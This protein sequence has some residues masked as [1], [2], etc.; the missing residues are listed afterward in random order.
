M[1]DNPSCNN[2]KDYNIYISFSFIAISL[3]V[4][5]LN[6]FYELIGKEIKNGK[7]K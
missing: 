2:V 4:G 1:C 7:E 5:C 3:C 6:S